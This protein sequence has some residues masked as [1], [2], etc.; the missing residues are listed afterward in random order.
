QK[1]AT[2]KLQE[3]AQLREELKNSSQ[4]RTEL[5]EMKGYLNLLASRL[6]DEDAAKEFNLA[7]RE[8]ALKNREQ[9]A[10]A[11]YAQST[12]QTQ[13]TSSYV[14]P[15]IEFAQKQQF[16]SEHLGDQAV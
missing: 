9:T 7:Q 11:G 1:S 16:L 13:Y 15:E 10:Q 6:L 3:A 4:T 8:L 5:Q 12:N 14:D 2:Q